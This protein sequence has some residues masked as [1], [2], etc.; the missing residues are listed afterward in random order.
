MADFNNAVERIVAGL[1]KR[2]RLL[3]PREREIVAYHEM[4]HALVALA[5]P[6]RRPGAQGLDH[7]ARRR[8]ARLHDPAPDR[9]PLPDDPRGAGEQDGG[10]ARRPRGG[11]DRVRPPLHRRRRRP[12]PRHRHRPRHGHA[13]RHVGE[14]RQ[15]R[16]GEGRPLLPAGRTRSA[17][18]P[19]E[20]DYSRR[21]R[22]GDRRRGARHRRR[23]L[24]AHASTS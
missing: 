1:E 18:A 12:R 2:N 10:A 13:L 24:R 15:R 16:P 21:D 17:T 23:R 3:N 7:P 14:A 9:G 8:R 11:A 22:D 5:L 19:R 20:R 4:G 6:G